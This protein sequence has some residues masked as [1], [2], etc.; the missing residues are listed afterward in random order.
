MDVSLDT[1]EL[2]SDVCKNVPKEHTASTVQKHAE[3]VA[4]LAIIGMETALQSVTLVSQDSCVKSYVILDH[5]EKNVA[6]HVGH[7][8]TQPAIP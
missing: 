4:K 3:T 8:P 5:L 7:A 2:M 1:T 6:K